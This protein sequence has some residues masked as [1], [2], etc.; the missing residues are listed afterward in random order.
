MVYHKLIQGACR[1]TTWFPKL[2]IAAKRIISGR[3][4]LIPG[5]PFAKHSNVQKAMLSGIL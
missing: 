1:L 2:A 4:L 3:N 5:N